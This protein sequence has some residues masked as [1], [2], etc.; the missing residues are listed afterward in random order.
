[1]TEVKKID[2]DPILSNS[3]GF[4]I[5]EIIAVIVI[6]GLLWALVATNFMGKVDEARQVDA[7]AQI[8][9]LGQALDLYRLEKGKYP[10]NEEGLKAIQ[11]YLK[12]ELPKDPW[13]NE[14]HYKSPGDHGDYDLVSYGADNAE[15]GEGNDLDIVSWK[16]IE[17]E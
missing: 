4:T 9:L 15:G 12:K 2:A 1:M 10:S 17:R 13:G 8:G 14:F 7:Q 16:N 11:T 3:K 5:L 6:I